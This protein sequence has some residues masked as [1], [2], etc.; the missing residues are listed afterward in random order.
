MNSRSLFRSVAGLLL[1]TGVALTLAQPA[2]AQAG[3]GAHW[4]GTWGAAPGVAS[5][6]SAFHFD[7][8][9]VRMIVHASTGGARVR[10]RLSNELGTAPISIGAAHIALRARENEIA[11]GSDRV[12]RFD[13]DPSITLAP[14]KAVMSDAVDLAV[15]P[16]SDLAISLYLPTASDQATMHSTASQTGYVS[17]TG[18]FSAAATF[19]VD[20]TLQSWPFLTEVD[21]EGDG[22]AIVA[23]GDSITDGFRSSRDANHRWPDRLAQR[24]QTAPGAQPHLGVVNRG[25]SG[26]RL[27][28]DAK[29]GSSFG[30]SILNRFDRDVL[31]TAGVRYMTL[32]I[33]INDISNSSASAPLTAD[34]L[35]GGYRQVIARA[36]ARGI[37][38]FGATITPFEGARSYSPELEALRQAA[39]DWIRTSNAFDGVIDFDRI[40]RD[41]AQATRLLPAYDSGDHLHPGDTGYEAMGNA[42]PLELFRAITTKQPVAAAQR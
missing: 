41:P 2:F 26:N 1:A 6:A 40:T 34:D 38:V 23:L 25:I 15:P 39:N 21:V 11:A 32:L 24:L 29:K 14:G 7:K 22:A 30:Q 13:G 18:D 5:G 37:L 3:G 31:A 19:P 9:T 10:V 20:R 17:S 42:V 27:L 35:I 4:V 12:L 36:H 28:A 8:Q 16:L 33:G